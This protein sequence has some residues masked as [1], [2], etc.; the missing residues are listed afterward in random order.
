MTMYARLARCKWWQLVMD[1]QPVSNRRWIT[2]VVM[3]VV[4]IYG[5][6]PKM[7]RT[8]ALWAVW[9]ANVLVLSRFM[10]TRDQ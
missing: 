7:K 10:K 5:M 4:G 2:C 8:Q 3:S 9:S 1:T 6:F